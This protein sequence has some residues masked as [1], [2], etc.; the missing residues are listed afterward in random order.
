MARID[1]EI[2]TR[3]EIAVGAVSPAPLDLTQ[4][5]GRVLVE[6]SVE[7]TERMKGGPMLNK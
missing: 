2:I 7:V 6:R 1:V 3:A 5:A 4:K